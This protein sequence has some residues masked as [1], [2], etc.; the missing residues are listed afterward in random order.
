MGNAL[1]NG[2]ILEGRYVIED[3]LGSGGFGITYLAKHR[4]LED[5]WVA[6][7]EYLPAGAAVRDSN[8]RVHAISKEHGKIYSWGLERFLD[9]ARL[10]R[11]FK[12]PNIVSVSDFFEAN[13]TA[14]LVMDYIQG[15]SIQADLD[16]GKK[17]DEDKLRC[18]VYPLLKA[19]K[20]IHHDGLYHRDISPD[21]ILLRE[22]DNS[23]V[24]IDFGSARYEMRMRGADQSDS[25][26]A[27]TPTSI[28]KQ[29]YS[30]IEQYEGTPQGPYTDIYALGATLYRTAFGIRPIEALTRSGEIRQ[31]K[32]DP[33]IPAREKG[34][35]RFSDECLRAI[36]AA[37][38]LE[39]ADRPQTTDAWLDIF[40]PPK[41]EENLP[42]PEPTHPPST[43]WRKTVTA[44]ILAVTVAMG[45][46]FGYR[47]YDA[48]KD[49]EALP[50]DI[51]GLLAYATTKLE[52]APFNEE[53]QNEARR[54]YLQ[55]LTQ[56]H[57]NTRALAGY[58]A[59][60]LLKQFNTSVKEEDQRKAV[61]LL[62]KTEGELKRAGIKREALEPGWQHIE[63]LNI[64]ASLRKTIYRAPLTPENWSSIESLISDISILPNSA[65]LA[66][67]GNRGLQ[68]LKLTKVF[69]TKNQFAK[70][71]EHLLI[72]EKR[73][74]PLGIGSLDVAKS[75][76]DQREA[77]F[78]ADGQIKISTLLQTAEQQL[79]TIPLTVKTLQSASAIY[80]EI[81]KLDSK[82]SKALAGRAL[83]EKLVSAYSA[84]EGSDFVTARNILDSAQRIAT[85]AGIAPDSLNQARDHL[86]KNLRTWT[87]E[88]KREQ[89]KAL[90]SDASKYLSKSP[91]DKG[92]LAQTTAL[93][94]QAQT[95]GADENELATEKSK[96]T[97]GIAL[98][99]ALLSVDEALEISDF[100]Q[101]RDALNAPQ[102]RALSEQLGVGSLLTTQAEKSIA[103]AETDWNYQQAAKI[104]KK[105]DLLLEANLDAVALHI[106]R[107]QALNAE[108]IQTTALSDAVAALRSVI[109]ARD[110]NDYT[111]AA[112]F[113]QQAENS[114]RT[115]DIAVDNL[116][117]AR[118]LIQ[119]ET[120][121][122]NLQQR[123]QKVTAMLDSAQALLRDQELNSDTLLQVKQIFLKVQKLQDNQ[124]QALTGIAMV[125][126]LENFLQA[127]TNSEFEKAEGLLAEADTQTRQA[128]FDPEFLNRATASLSTARNNWQ[129]ELTKQKIIDLLNKA[130]TLVNET[131][132]DKE[133]L[134]KAEQAYHEAVSHN[135]SLEGIEVNVEQISSGLET[136]SLLRTFKA[137]LANKQF[138]ATKKTATLLR[139]RLDAANL[140]QSIADHLSARATEDEITWRMNQA[141]DFIL[142]G[143]WSK[144]RNFAPAVDQYEIIQ[145]ISPDQ[146]GVDVALLG[147]KSLN[148]TYHAREQR[149]YEQAISFLAQA[150]TYFA[151]I[152]IPQETFAAFNQQLVDEQQR[153]E[154]I[155]QERTLIASTSTAIRE[156]SRSP[157][158]VETWK[159]IESLAAKTLS[160]RDKDE[161]GLA[162]LRALN[163][164]RQAKQDI[165]DKQFDAATKHVMLAQS[166]LAN[167]GLRKPLQNALDI[168][169]NEARK[170]SS[171]QITLANRLI[172]QKQ[173]SDEDLH[174]AISALEKV[175]ED[176]SKKLI[177]QTSIDILNKLL[178]ARAATSAT[179]Y[180]EAVDILNQAKDVFA[181]TP[182]S[183][184]PLPQLGKLLTL[185][186]EE[187]ANERPSPGEIYPIIS[188]ALSTIAEAPLEKEKLDTAEKLLQNVLGLQADEH[189]AWVGL[190]AIKHLRITSA[191]LSGGSLNDARAALKLAQQH[192]LEIGLAPTTLQSAWRAI[193]QAATDKP[194]LITNPSE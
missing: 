120:E 160:T 77:Q 101:A 38:Q 159:S 45:G 143:A 78:I 83:I 51:P 100:T 185:T 150:I 149:D 23:P 190:Q 107:I 82:Q 47:W 5:I 170:F 95:I 183:E 11:Q 92:A 40:G 19:L 179:K 76:I 7:K 127:L 98:A 141:R 115:S 41:E 188:I 21:N 34:K 122:W 189:S 50:T 44:G 15:R 162:V 151:D 20:L 118:D 13:N 59:A 84:I 73:L 6:I 36:D 106:N 58:S 68:A 14:Y 54:I 63:L 121:A 116:A 12:H 146:P 105:R 152:D 126:T 174:T 52:K 70:A 111:A 55:I 164:L 22:Q 177:A 112:N 161:R 53:N 125:S 74:T 148:K 194:N 56:D 33:L 39:A 108:R 144:N 96:A 184:E 117:A 129:N 169:D 180:R 31:T 176:N 88:N 163:L 90:F 75:E 79:L 66:E 128:R 37:L 72:A 147:I 186:Q 43:K 81:L 167:I 8:S 57:G 17:F 178:E 60:N 113:L 18:I 25:D 10:L 3:K 132:L 102:I 166:E 134:N 124:T 173:V 89:I 110:N 171:S 130:A 138:E 35:G 2:Y 93:Y 142:S 62:D 131:P 26:Q 135:R 29:G 140:D 172:S 9:E 46:Y 94:Q 49:I 114:L 61:V 71:R 16:A 165:D 91:L 80:D 48:R 99:G 69:A 28:F 97:S 65:S 27:H 85:N 156:M 181:A 137:E 32:T 192:L 123:E 175:L 24:L 145:R 30:P 1:P 168:I 109:S 154:H 67:S 64:L 4:Y 104:F 182:S 158:S 103:K 42:E 191:T 133:N 87:I 157:F 136:L 139:Y 155:I 187:V 86:A 193:D 119:K 153:W